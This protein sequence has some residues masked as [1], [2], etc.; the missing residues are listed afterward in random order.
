MRTF[1]TE[2]GYKFYEQPDGNLTDTQDPA[3][4]DLTYNSLDELKAAVD[5]TEL[6]AQQKES[7]NEQ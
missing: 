3:D 4:A 5:A 7:T 6:P 1:Q 2:D